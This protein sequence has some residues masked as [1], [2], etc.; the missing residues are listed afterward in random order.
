MQLLQPPRE[1]DGGAFLPEVAL[2]LAGNSQGGERGEFETQVGVEALD[3][4]DQAQVPDLDDVVERL[5]AILELACE[6]IN[7][8]V[9][10]VDQLLAQPISLGGVFAVPI[11]AME[12]PQLLAGNPRLRQMQPLVVGRQPA[13]YLTIRKRRCPVRGST[14][15]R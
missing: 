7:E 11:T 4:L 2:D 8:V 9:I 13:R 10:A 6:E 3:G 5:A 1:A 14:S 15:G 12:R